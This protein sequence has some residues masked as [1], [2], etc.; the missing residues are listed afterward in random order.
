[1]LGTIVCNHLVKYLRNSTEGGN[2][3]EYWIYKRK[4]FTEQGHF[5][6]DC[7]ANRLAMK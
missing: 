3:A 4:R 1:M 2:E 5:E 6:V 7:E